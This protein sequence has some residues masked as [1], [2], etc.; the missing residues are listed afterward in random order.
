[1]NKAVLIGIVVAS[2]LTGC[3]TQGSGVLPIIGPL[4]SLG[5]YETLWTFPTTVGGYYDSKVRRNRMDD[6]YD[7]TFYGS[8]IGIPIHGMTGFTSLDSWPT[9]RQGGV[10]IVRGATAS[11]KTAQWLISYQP[12][13]MSIKHFPECEPYTANRQSGDGK[14]I[15]F[16]DPTHQSDSLFA[17]DI[18]KDQLGQYEYEQPPVKKTSTQTSTSPQSRVAAGKPSASKAKAAIPS[19]PKI[20]SVKEYK[21]GSIQIQQVPADKGQKAVTWEK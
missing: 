4:A 18:H 2:L 7:M 21:T 20:T 15:M 19:P 14:Y 17:Y 8:L 12:D 11:C 3:S 6:T 16:E 1:M 13:G 10:V 5:T 9:S